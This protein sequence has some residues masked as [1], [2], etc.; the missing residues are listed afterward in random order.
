MI[1]DRHRVRFWDKRFITSA[2]HIPKTARQH[3]REQ[4]SRLHHIVMGREERSGRMG[5]HKKSEKIS[6]V[7]GYQLNQSDL[8]CKRWPICFTCPFEDCRQTSDNEES[9]DKYVEKKRKKKMTNHNLKIRSE[10]YQDV[11]EEKKTF[12]LRKNDRDYKVG[13]TIKLWEIDENGEKTGRMLQ[14]V[15]TYI[16]KD[17]PQYGLDSEYVILG[18]AIKGKTASWI[19]V[20]EA[21]FQCSKCKYIHHGKEDTLTKHCPECGRR[22]AMTQRDIF[23]T[24]NRCMKD[25]EAAG[26]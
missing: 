23:R 1:P 25:Y 16:L 8:G 12:E 15:I 2:R 14:R 3:L 4:D 10:Y 20:G 26:Q 17:V 24:Y 18:I 9:K 13:D 6:I 22:M 5:R 7:K 21:E 11:M 19:E